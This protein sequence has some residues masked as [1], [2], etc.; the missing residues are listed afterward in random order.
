MQV[1]VGVDSTD[2]ATSNSVLNAR[3]SC[4]D[5][6]DEGLGSGL[7]RTGFTN[8]AL[9]RWAGCRSR[10]RLVSNRRLDLLRHLH[11]LLGLRTTQHGTLTLQSD[12]AASV[13]IM[14]FHALGLGSGER[15]GRTRPQNG[16]SQH[17]TPTTLVLHVCASQ[18][19]F[20]PI[21]RDLGSCR[22]MPGFA[23][24]RRQRGFESRWG[25]KIN[26]R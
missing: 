9:S 3:N 24:S 10:M 26:R 17:N 6:Y 14:L 1:S 20:Q 7:R 12:I 23:L 16:E 4:A 8:C 15:G 2:T 21:M 5:A 13:L 22:K 18:N 19:R 25:H 11:S